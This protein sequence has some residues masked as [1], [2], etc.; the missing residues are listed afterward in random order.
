MKKL[1]VLA[2][3]FSAAAVYL[4]GSPAEA[5]KGKG[6]SSDG[7]PFVACE[8]KKAGDACSFKDRDGETV[9]GVCKKHEGR[10]EKSE[11]LF[12][13]NER[14]GDKMPAGDGKGH[15]K[16]PHMDKE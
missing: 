10:G 6:V 15:K 3:V 7:N 13:W 1:L 14:M 4:T 2:F 9:E 11:A 12:C 5:K 8:S 16:C